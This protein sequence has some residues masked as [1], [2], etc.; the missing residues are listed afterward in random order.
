M[1]T[2]VDDMTTEELT[3]LTE[4]TAHKDV[5]VALKAVAALRDHAEK[6]EAELV[7]K[8]RQQGSTWATIAE[9]L[10]VSK[11]AVHKKYVG[12][13]EPGKCTKKKAA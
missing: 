4:K 5:I 12:D 11:Q 3:A 10:S 1:S 8:A 6:V 2:K 7:D 9:A 13:R